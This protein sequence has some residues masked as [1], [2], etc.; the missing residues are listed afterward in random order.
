MEA[1]GG[2]CQHQ[3][4]LAGALLRIVQKRHDIG[5]EVGVDWVQDTTDDPERHIWLRYV[6]GDEKV[7]I[8]DSRPTSQAFR[9]EHPVQQPTDRIYIGPDDDIQLNSG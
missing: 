1:G 5:G 4:L 9:L 6:R 3:T 7:I 2:I 8:D